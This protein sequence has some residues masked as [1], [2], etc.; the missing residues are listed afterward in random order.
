MRFV[1]PYCWDGLVSLGLFSVHHLCQTRNRRILISSMNWFI[2]WKSCWYCNIQQRY[3]MI[4]FSQ[5]HAALVWPTH[6]SD[7]IP[8][9]LHHFYSL[10]ITAPAHLNSLKSVKPQW[11]FHSG[12]I[13]TAL[14]GSHDVGGR[15][16]SPCSEP[17]SLTFLYQIWCRTEMIQTVIRLSTITFSKDLL[18]SLQDEL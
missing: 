1:K 18:P 4:R 14:D 11:L 7:N 9:L 8:W 5:H 16:T 2:Y 15:L 13:E 12:H 10:F 3:Y 17:I 6:Q